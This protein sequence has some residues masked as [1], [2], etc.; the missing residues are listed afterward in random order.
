MTVRIHKFKQEILPVK[1]TFPSFHK[2]VLLDIATLQ[3]LAVF[4]YVKKT[5]QILGNCVHYR[6]E[7]E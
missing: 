3:K 4:L 2:R 1:D 6:E 7:Q 5:R